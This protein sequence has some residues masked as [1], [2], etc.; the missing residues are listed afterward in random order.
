MDSFSDFVRSSGSITALLVVTICVGRPLYNLFIHP[1]RSIP[2]PWYTRASVLPFVFWLAT[3]ELASATR[4]MHEEYGE[5]LRLAPNKLSFI[6]SQAWLDI[7]GHRNEKKKAWF[8]KDPTVYLPR[9]NGAPSIVDANEQDH[10]RF[11]R[12]LAHAFSEKALRD[13]E[14]ILQTYVNL[15]ISKLH[16]QIDGPSNGLL[17]MA[18]W[19]NF[20]TFDIIGELTFGR[21]F[22]C[23]E[24][25]E[26]HPWIGLLPGAARTM[27]YLLALKHAPGFVFNLIVAIVMP[28]LNTRREHQ[29]FTN[30]KIKVR[31]SDQTE[32]RDF[33]TPIIKANDEKGMTYSELESSINLLVTAGSE[34]LATFFSGAIYHLSQNPQVMKKLREEVQKAFKDAKDITMA[35]TR[36]LP[37]LNAVIEESLRIYPPA[38]L[39]LSRIVPHGGASIC[40]QNIPEGTGVGVTSWAATHSQKNFAA[41]EEYAPERWLGD[42]RFGN[43]DKQA[44]QPFSLGARNCV[45]KNLAYAEMRLVLARLAFDFDFEL[46]PDSGKWIVQ[47]LFTFWEKPPLIMKLTRAHEAEKSEAFA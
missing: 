1:L 30:E 40:G 35:L 33:I 41:P 45:G 10:A 27:T 31:L 16:D 12:L 24:S 20:M 21:S 18:E 7:H 37:Y 11:R 29:M 8:E 4:R 14:Q 5:T 22:S 44:S 23:L 9:F 28:F 26:L 15:L 34:T 6:N 17:D 47:K 19:V 13:Q 32:R 39:S 38:A 43:D 3:G 42:L 2:G 46:Q 25:G 36:D